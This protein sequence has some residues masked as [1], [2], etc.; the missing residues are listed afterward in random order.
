MKKN[1]VILIIIIISC[2]SCRNYKEIPEIEYSK[3]LVSEPTPFAK[4]VIST[5]NNSEFELTFSADGLTAYF[6][7][8]APEEKQMIYES[9]FVK[10]NWTAPQLANFSTSRAETAMITPNG[11]FFF[12][13]SERPIPNKPNKGNFDMN[14]WM[15]EKTASG[16]GEPKPLPEPINQV[17]VEG[18]KWPSSNNNFLFTND[19]ETFYYT[20]MIRGDSTIKLYKT[21]FD[22]TIFSEPE[23]VRGFLMKKNIWFIRQ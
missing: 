3:V 23:T 20:T 14:I 2:I 10:G 7:R 4:G 5:E 19:N 9:T 15:M 1:D 6:S 12:F 21:I 11:K 8:R 16:W 18:E 17:Q 13:G 22:G